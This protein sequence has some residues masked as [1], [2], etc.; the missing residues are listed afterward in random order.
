MDLKFS[1]ADLEF[2]AEARSFIDKYWPLSARKGNDVRDRFKARSQAEERW[3]EALAGAGWSVP[4][5]PP[6]HGGTDWTP[7]QK[8]IWDQATAAAGCP[9]M[10]P[11]G[12]RMLAPV[13][14]TWG[15]R[16]QQERFLPPIR[17][18]KAQ[19]C[20]GYS[21]PN[22]GSDLAALGT[23]A[24][25]EGDDYLIN[26]AKT[27][28]TGAHTADWMFCLARTDTST[29]KPQQGISFFLID[30]RSEGVSVEPIIMLGDIHSVNNVVLDNVCVPVNQR[31]GE[32]N[33]GWTY[34]KGLLAHE[35]TGI[36]GVAHSKEQIARL[37]QIAAE[38]SQDGDSLAQDESFLDKI[39]KVEIEWMALEI[40]ELRVL[41]Q[42]E[43]GNAPGP[44]SSILKIKGTEISQR[45]AELFVEAY[46][47]Y[48]IPYPQMHYLDNE[49]P[50]GPESAMTGVSGF[51]LGRASSIFGGSNE[52]QRNIIAKSVLNL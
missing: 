24:V 46:G 36:A 25:R 1:T 39:R 38:T 33:K 35:R 9:A 48:S 44:E 52:I 43:K 5:W 8:Y 16:E 34:A 30:M 26:G 12:A 15:T 20:Q 23:K 13:L 37:R 7:T 47:Y 50:I 19:W 4:N 31:I 11:F 14:Y 21:E 41:A 40:T 27:W 28:T 10:S 32:E 22:A 6:E 49:G 51:L 29:A 42:I 45:I 17:E 18:A 3:F 2:Q